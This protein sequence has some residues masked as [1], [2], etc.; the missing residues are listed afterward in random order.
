MGTAGAVT[1]LVRH[2]GAPVG[3]V[4]FWGTERTFLEH[5]HLLVSKGPLTLRGGAH[6]TIQVPDRPLCAMSGLTRPPGFTPS[7]CTAD[8]EFVISQS[9]SQ[10]FVAGGL[11]PEGET[12]GASQDLPL[13][14]RQNSSRKRAPEFAEPGQK[15]Q[16]IY[17]SYIRVAWHECLRSIAVRKHACEHMYVRAWPTTTTLHD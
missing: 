1:P 9:R 10:M 13:Q 16:K 15:L 3:G 5:R 6:P 7:S 11:C 4:A 17:I 12:K 2:L 14:P 8:F